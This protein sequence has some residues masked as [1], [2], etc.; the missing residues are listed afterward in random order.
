MP[1]IITITGPSGAGKSSTLKCLCEEKREYFNPVIV[2]KYTNRP[3]HKDDQNEV[4]CVD[5]IPNSCDLK[6]IQYGDYYGIALNTILEHIM[7]Q[8]S[9]IVI[10]N[11]VRAVEDVKKVFG[12]IVRSLFI[13]RESPDEKRF[14]E[15]AD[16]KGL[17]PKE[18]KSRLQ[19]AKTLYRIYIENIHIF[20]HVIINSSKTLLDLSVQ[21]KQ[22]VDSLQQSQ[23]WPLKERIRE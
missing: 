19:K 8:K 2:P 18:I 1:Y 10:L 14:Q 9:P 15:I 17:D 5:E 4:I 22:I 21:V 13:F 23:K 7:A 11:D 20:D 3:P 6:Y 16:A 12:G